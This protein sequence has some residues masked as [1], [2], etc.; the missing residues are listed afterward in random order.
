MYSLGSVL[1]YTQAVQ[2]DIERS[3]ENY[4]MIYEATAEK[5]VRPTLRSRI[6]Q[7]FRPTFEQIDTFSNSR[8]EEVKV[9]ECT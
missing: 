6:A 3:I 5:T 9:A 1:M 8:A 2:A 7:W 4:R